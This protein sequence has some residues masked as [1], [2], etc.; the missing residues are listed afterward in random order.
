MANSQSA[1]IIGILAFA[2]LAAAAIFLFSPG[3]YDDFAKCL[4]GKGAKMYGAFWCAH[5]KEQKEM[6]GKSW[7]YVDYVECSAPD[8]NTELDICK[9]ANVTQYPTWVFDNESRRSGPLTFQEIS[10]KSGCP[11]PLS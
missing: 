8:G 5:C 7:Q 1:L 4:S 3:K 6:F 10:D 2:V 11:L 9:A